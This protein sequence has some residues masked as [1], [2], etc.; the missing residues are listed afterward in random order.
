MLHRAS[1]HKVSEG[2]PCFVLN[3][4]RFQVCAIAVQKFS[5]LFAV[6]PKAF[7]LLD[8]HIH[9][10]V[11]VIQSCPPWSARFAAADASDRLHEEIRRSVHGIGVSFQFNRLPIPFKV[12][13]DSVCL[14]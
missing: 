12:K 2:G 6:E 1:W 9:K 14:V 8:E 4:D 5:Q 3:A 10:I 7:L 11:H 13:L